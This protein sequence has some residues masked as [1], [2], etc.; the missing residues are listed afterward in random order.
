L[1]AVHHSGRLRS[2]PR[3]V[4]RK[5]G[6]VGSIL[7]RQI[8]IWKDEPGKSG[9][10]TRRWVDLIARFYVMDPPLKGRACGL[11]LAVSSLPLGLLLPP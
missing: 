4:T 7:P 8:T 9:E 3:G 11:S 10:T 6:E 5:E 2:T 1:A